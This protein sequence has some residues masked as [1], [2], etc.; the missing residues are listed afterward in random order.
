MRRSNKTSLRRAA[1]ALTAIGLALATNSG[2]GAS[3]NVY[4]APAEGRRDTVKAQ[5][6]NQRAADLIT[7]DPDESERLLREALAAD[8]YYGPAHNNLGVVYL[9]RGSLYE[10]AHEF[11]WAR[12]LLPGDPDP[13]LNLAI[14]LEQAGRIDDAINTYQTA[15]DVRPEHLPTIEALA[16]CRVINKQRT[17]ETVQ[18]LKTIALRSSPTWR[19]WAHRQLIQHE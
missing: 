8:L 12:K 16:R 7:T 1:T 14:T 3:R 18:L 19:D 4:T 2:C 6:L 10:A 5:R 15:L 13:R 17:V 11:E 9:T